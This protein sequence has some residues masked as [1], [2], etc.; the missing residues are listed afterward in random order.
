MPTQHFPLT[1]SD[2]TALKAD[3][4]DFLAKTATGVTRNTEQT[5]ALAVDYNQTTHPGVLRFPVSSGEIWQS[6]NNSQ[7]M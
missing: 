6:S 2:S 5:G 4:W 7:N 3:G 1:Y